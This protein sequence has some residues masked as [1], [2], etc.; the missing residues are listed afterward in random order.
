MFDFNGFKVNTP[1]RMEVMQANTEGLHLYDRV[2]KIYFVIEEKN[3]VFTLYKRNVHPLRPTQ[4]AL[5]SKDD[6][7]SILY[8]LGYKTKGYRK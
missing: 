2:T 6:L 5:L 8:L 1:Q 7:G 4:D 3:G